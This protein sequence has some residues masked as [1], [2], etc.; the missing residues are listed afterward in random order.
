M[1]KSGRSSRFRLEASSRPPPEAADESARASRRAGG[2]A[3]AVSCQPLPDGCELR[4]LRSQLLPAQRGPHHAARAG[5]D[6]GPATGPHEADALGDVQGLASAW[7]CQAVRALF[8]K[9]TVF[10]RT[11]SGLRGVDDD[12]EPDIAGNPCAGLRR[13]AATAGAPRSDRRVAGERAGVD[14]EPVP[15]VG[16]E[17]PLVCLV[18]LVGAD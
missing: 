7:E 10:I 12:V 18:D 9:R 16:G 17:H 15:D 13:W 3:G 8:A 14:D 5:P 1:P 6:D 11:R 4:A 2:Q